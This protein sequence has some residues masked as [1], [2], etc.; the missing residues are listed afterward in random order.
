M[1]HFYPV[2]LLLPSWP[3]WLARNPAALGTAKND[4]AKSNKRN[5]EEL[6]MSDF[7]KAPR[8]D[9]PLDMTVGKARVIYALAVIGFSK[10][11]YP[12]GWVL[13]GGRRTQ[14]KIEAYRAAEWMN[15]L[16]GA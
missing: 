4:G 1:V 5:L 2:V 16:M 12:E 14:D 15:E 11:I 3:G 10:V 9:H 6:G 13:P 8:F 7:D